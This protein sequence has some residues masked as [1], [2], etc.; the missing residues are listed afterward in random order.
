MKWLCINCIEWVNDTVCPK[1][2]EN[3]PQAGLMGKPSYEERQIQWYR[4][5]MKGKKRHNVFSS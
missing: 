1:C 3:M 5:T 4:K 2:L